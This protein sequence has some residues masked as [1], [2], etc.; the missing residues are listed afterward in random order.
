MR[1][2]SLFQQRVQT[3]L[4]PLQYQFRSCA[5]AGAAPQIAWLRCGASPFISAPHQTFREQKAF[6]SGTSNPQK[7]K[8]AGSDAK[9]GVQHNDLK[10]T[11]KVIP[12]KENLDAAGRG[13]VRVDQ[14]YDVIIVG[15][16]VT[17]TALLYEL[18][19]FTD[20]KRLALVERRN[21]VSQV[22]SF[23]HNNSQ[24]IHCGDIETNYT[25]AKAK[26]VL[27]Q[28]NMLRNWATKLPSEVSDRTVMK[29]PKMALGVGSEETTFLAERYNSIKELF[30]NLK[31]INKKQI[32]DAEPCV[33]MRN[34]YCERTDEINAL[35]S[36]DE[37]TAVDYYNCARNFLNCALQTD[38]TVDLAIGK[39]VKDIQRE[40]NEFRVRVGNRSAKARFVVVSACGHSLLLAQKMGYAKEFS[41]LPVAGSFYFTAVHGDPDVVEKGVTRFGPTALPLPL[42][43][44][45][46]SSTFWDFMKVLNFD[47]SL[48]SFY[49]Q[50]LG[51]KKRRNY[52]FN[53][54]LFEV[55]KLNTYLFQKTVSKIVPSIRIQDLTYAK[56]FGGVRPQLV[57]KTEK[58][59]LMGEGKINPGD[60]IIFNVTPSPGGTTCLG[61]GEVDMREICNK[62]GANI[63]EAK[64]TET[65]L[66]GE[67]SVVH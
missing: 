27:R 21:D 64:F 18:A 28:A 15:G 56:G 61:N 52:L 9:Q 44:R 32:R 20:L 23:P 31:L 37:H 65:L 14:T 54:V 16:G 22:A 25:Y 57:N 30:P 60:G 2:L 51:T 12:W 33:V 4:S 26:T 8:A 41:C 11:I 6:T 7:A 47:T 24:T 66:K 1:R 36:P 5:R 19:A 38:K 13:N 62:L 10:S 40:G 58:K 63:D 48:I 59:L 55:P 49:L 43:E 42:L 45:Y 67:Y 39:E 3:H 34:S 50:E 29:Y 46:N 35:Y 53:N 17:G